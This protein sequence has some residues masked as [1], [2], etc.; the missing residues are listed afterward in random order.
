MGTLAMRPTE[1]QVVATWLGQSSCH[2]LFPAAAC[3]AVAP[4]LDSRTPPLFKQRECSPQRSPLRPRYGCCRFLS[5]CLHNLPILQVKSF[6]Y[7]FFFPALSLP[8]RS[9]SCP[10]I[11]RAIKPTVTSIQPRR[12]INMMILNPRASKIRYLNA[13]HSL[14]ID[15]E[16][17]VRKVQVCAVTIS[18]AH[19]IKHCS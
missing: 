8:N 5:A 4:P 10:D 13:S 19:T 15:L 16:K 1:E 18:K 2:Q 9:R 14:L 17:H 6:A 3:P 7:S 11:S 12:Q